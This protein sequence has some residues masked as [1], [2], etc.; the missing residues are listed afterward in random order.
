MAKSKA[1]TREFPFHRH[2]T[3]TTTHEFLCRLCGRWWGEYSYRPT[4]KGRELLDV[5]L[6]GLMASLIGTARGVKGP[7]FQRTALGEAP[8]TCRGTIS[9]YSWRCF[10][11]CRNRPKFSPETLA[12]RLRD[13][14]REVLL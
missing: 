14:P 2:H 12:Q 5:R 9:L 4:R 6:P 11:S 13:T 8:L 3:K 10:G 1:R 7:F